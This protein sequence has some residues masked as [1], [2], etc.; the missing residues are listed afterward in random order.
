MLPDEHAHRHWVRHY[1]E[2]IRRQTELGKDVQQHQ[3]DARLSG[4]ARTFLLS[5]AALFFCLGMLG[6]MFSR[7]EHW[8]FSNGVYF[9]LASTLTVGYGSP[10]PTTTAS[11]VLLLPAVLIS[12]ML[13]YNQIASIVSVLE[14]FRNIRRDKWRERLE[15][16]IEREHEHLILKTLEDDGQPP[17]DKRRLP[18]HDSHWFSWLQS[19]WN[20]SHVRPSVAVSKNA[21]PHSKTSVSEPET[22][23]SIFD[24]KYDRFVQLLHDKLVSGH[25][26][27]PMESEMQRIKALT[28]REKAELVISDLSFSIFLFVILL[29]VGAA[30]F[31]RTESWS[32]GNALYFSYISVLT[33]GFGDFKPNSSA[34]RIT[35]LI[36]ALTAVPIVTTFVVQTIASVGHSAAQRMSAQ[37]KF[38]AVRMAREADGLPTEQPTIVSQGALLSRFH[39]QITQ[40]LARLFTPRRSKTVHGL[41][42]EKETKDDVSA[43]AKLAQELDQLESSGR[44]QESAA[45][46][47]ADRRLVAAGFAQNPDTTSDVQPSADAASHQPTHDPSKLSDPE[48]GSGTQD[49]AQDKID[50]LERLLC[51]QRLLLDDML[52]T[53]YMLDGLV[54]NLLLRS[55]PH[56]SDAWTVLRADTKLHGRT[57]RILDQFADQ[58]HE[59][60]ISSPHEPIREMKL[61]EHRSPEGKPSPSGPTK[62]TSK[63][64]T[65]RYGLEPQ[66]RLDRVRNRMFLQAGQLKAEKERTAQYIQRFREGTARVSVFGAELERVT[67]AEFTLLAEA[68]AHRHSALRQDQPIDQPFRAD[69]VRETK[70]EVDQQAIA[71]AVL[72]ERH[73]LTQ[74]YLD[75]QRRLRDMRDRALYVQGPTLDQQ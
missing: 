25:G 6:F 67:D 70:T 50:K 71:E 68:R 16:E 27:L 54:R 12:T 29:I 22:S 72:K 56:G 61:G 44:L 58:I 60:N 45:L 49:P 37:H 17:G 21:S 55:L 42:P 5:Q 66:A 39:H 11:K 18:A 33:I 63:N 65:S 46:V 69:E 13:L 75:A 19:S 35:W 32:F 23:S 10:Q 4:E 59:V 9:F 64:D 1:Q 36:Y 7:I 47:S 30:I 38:K 57:L 20:H 28:G 51:S 62:S 3:R 8:T 14:R 43:T 73:R 53:T 52:D 74:N 40:E 15:Q 48:V 34:G 2:R 26:E 31:A 24:S 41:D